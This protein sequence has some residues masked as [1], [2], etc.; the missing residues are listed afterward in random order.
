MAAKTDELD[1]VETTEDMLPDNVQAI[2][3]RDAKLKKLEGA[4]LFSYVYRLEGDTGS[5]RI[6][7]GRLD[8]VDIDDYQIGTMFGGPAVYQVV[9][10]WSYDGEPPANVRKTGS[11]S[12]NIFRI[13]AEY[14]TP[15]SKVAVAIHGPLAQPG[16]AFGDLNQALVLVNALTD[17]AVKLQGAQPARSESALDP[18]K[19]ISLMARTA[20]NFMEKQTRLIDLGNRGNDEPNIP[21]AS[22]PGTG[23][24]DLGELLGPAIQKMAG[25]FIE[26][27]AEAFMKGGK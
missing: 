14:G 12:D 19:M 18:S 10:R 13:G 6:S 17:M 8:G 9:G 16:T 25:P 21:G 20:E 5:K 4:R 2:K 15:E 3:K 26:K 22:A 1:E 24:L 27:L 23:G 11:F 7:V